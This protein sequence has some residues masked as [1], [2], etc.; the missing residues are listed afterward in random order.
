MSAGVS[1]KMSQFGADLSKLFN[2]FEDVVFMFLFGVLTLNALSTFN[3]ELSF[4]LGLLWGELR[5]WG[6]FLLNI[7]FLFEVGC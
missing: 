4:L 5:P 1:V 2:A 3:K 6:V 7:F